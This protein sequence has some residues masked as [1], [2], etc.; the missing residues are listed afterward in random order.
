MRLF[1]RGHREEPAIIAELRKI[2]IVVSGEQTGYV[3]CEGH[4]RGHND[5]VA[6]NVPDAPKTPHILEMKTIND[7]GYKELCK[8]GVEEAR[9]AYY[10]QCQAYMKAGKYKRALFIAVNK[11]TDA[12]YVE[13][14]RYDKGYADD[15][16]RKAEWILT[17]KV[18]FPN[19]F[20]PG[21]YACGWCA[22]K[23]VCRGSDKPEVS[24]RSCKHAGPVQEGEWYCSLHEGN[25][26]TDFQRKGCKDYMC[27]EI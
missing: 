24:C 16:T 6:E 14:I 19:T 12:W 3:A 1:D 20:P 25:I 10:A 23:Y 13:R 2:G 26:P 9:P 18:P 15:L 17:N 4:Y 5:G 11:N 7:K 22:A 27:Y 21:W 8:K